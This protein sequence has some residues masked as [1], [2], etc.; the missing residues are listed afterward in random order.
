MWR[1]AVPEYDVFLSHYS[2]DEA[3]AGELER[4]LRTAGVSVWYDGAE[5]KLGDSILA[6]MQEGLQKSRY[7]LILFTPG[8]LSTST[9]FRWGEV[10]AYLAEQLAD[11]R[12]HLLPLVAGVE[13]EEYQRKMPL[14]RARRYER[15]ALN[16][17][18]KASRT[19]LHRVVQIISEVATLRTLVHLVGRDELNSTFGG[20]EDRLPNTREVLMASG[21][22]C[23]ALVESKSGFLARALDRGVKIKIMCVDPQ[24][25]LAVETLTKIDPRFDDAAD[26][27][28]SMQAVE[29]VLTKFRTSYP[30]LFEFRYMPIAPS[31]GLYISDSGLPTAL[32]KVEIYTPK[33]WNPVATR[34][35]IVIKRDSAWR[36]YF[37]STWENYWNMSRVPA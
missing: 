9:G 20:L 24:S 36:D 21:N 5:I 6:K 16:K 2:G 17:N 19:E 14:L 37:L 25:P 27:A 34:P 3:L 18:G 13:H 1:L 29:R 30:N 28:L 31:V 4:A 7:G 11:S 15:I 8:F 33:P 26:F 32:M 22:D 12:T 10:D 23:K 35:H